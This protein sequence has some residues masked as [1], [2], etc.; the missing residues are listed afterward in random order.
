MVSIDVKNKVHT[1]LEKS[2]FYEL[3]GEENICPNINV[4]LERAKRIIQH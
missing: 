1:L 3:W 4:E 2:G